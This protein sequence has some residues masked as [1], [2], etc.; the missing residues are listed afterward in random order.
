VLRRDGEALGRQSESFALILRPVVK[1]HSG[2]LGIGSGEALRQAKRI[3][4]EMSPSVYQ[5]T[6]YLK[7]CVVGSPAPSTSL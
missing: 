4:R 7:V 5:I 2:R 3:T 1:Q 6:P